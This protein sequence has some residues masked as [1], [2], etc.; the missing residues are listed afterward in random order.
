MDCAPTGRQNLL[1]KI[2]TQATG[3]GHRWPGIQ[4]HF[5]IPGSVLPR[6]VCSTVRYHNHLSVPSHHYSCLEGSRFPNTI[7]NKAPS[8]PRTLM[9]SSLCGHSQGTL[10][11]TFPL[12]SPHMWFHLQILSSYLLN[13]SPVLWWHGIILVLILMTSHLLVT[14]CA[15]LD[16]NTLPHWAKSPLPCVFSD[17]MGHQVE[18]C[19]TLMYIPQAPTPSSRLSFSFLPPTQTH[20][21][22]QKPVSKSLSLRCLP[23]SIWPTLGPLPAASSHAWVIYQR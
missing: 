6:L 1:S 9:S 3:A 8:Y 15:T 11:G 21:V 22:N 13:I 23:Q 18:T 5:V 2:C 7:A 16:A 19:P 4:S 17:L 20:F 12:V 10:W 14:P